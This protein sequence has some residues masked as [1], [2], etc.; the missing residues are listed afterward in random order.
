MAKML[1][2]PVNIVKEAT[3][4]PS[5]EIPIITATQLNREAYRK[6]KHKE[7]GMETV[8]E[9]IPEVFIADFGAISSGPKVQK[10]GRM[11]ID[12]PSRSKQF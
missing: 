2:I 5:F 8:S 9:S 7:F 6:E 4:F 11:E 10:M 12:H 1:P 3:I